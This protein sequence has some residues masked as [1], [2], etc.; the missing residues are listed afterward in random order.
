MKNDKEILEKIKNSI[1]KEKKITK[2]M[3]SLSDNL[4]RLSSLEERRVV[5]T[6]II[7]LKIILRK[8]SKEVVDLIRQ[9]LVVKRLE[10]VIKPE[11]MPD[12]EIGKEKRFLKNISGRDEQPVIKIDISKLDISE[13][14]KDTVKRLK[15]REERIIYR[16]ERKSN[17]YVNTANRVFANASKKLVDK[18]IFKPLEKELIKSNMKFVPV[19]YISTLLFSTALAVI[20]SIFL[21]I[22]LMIFSVSAELPI[23]ALATESPLER[24]LKFFWLLFVIPVGISVFM[25]FYPSLERKATESKIDQELPF[26]TIH[27]S[28]I[29]GT[30]I[31]PSKIFSIIISTREYPYLEKEFIKLINEVNVYGYDL[32]GALRNMALKSPSNKLAEL[33]NGLATTINSGGDLVNFFEKRSESLLL[34]YRLEREK[35]TKSA[36]TFMDIYISIV[37]AA[38]MILM[39]LLMMMKISGLGITLSTGM[40][41]LMM[42]SAVSLINVIFLTFLQVKQPGA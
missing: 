17:F 38:P 23:I 25:Y 29:S 41:T 27:M 2:E 37:I 15:K 19:N 7:N 21:L 34:E 10:P 35:Y 31:E 13:L 42:I 18:E 40:I 24:F 26:A 20:F 33:Y 22:F 8:T 30:M 28:A 11:K 12:K 32:S 3:L 1:S 36:E 5:L 4:K 9:I 39:L 16:K 6:Q 14:E